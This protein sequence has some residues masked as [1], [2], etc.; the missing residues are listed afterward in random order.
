MPLKYPKY[1]RR[2]VAKGRDY[3]YFDTGKVVDG[4][5]VLVALPH[6]RDPRFGGSYAALMGHRHRPHAGDV[7]RIPKLVDLYE[8]SPRFRRRSEATKRLYS[9][10]LRKLEALLPTAPVSE[11]TRG[12]IRKLVDG[13]ADTPGAAN[14]FLKVCGVLFAW[15]KEG[16]YI[17]RNPCDGLAKFEGGEHDPWPDHIVNAALE[18]EDRTVRLL[19]HLLLYTAQRIGDVVRMTWQDLANGR[20]RVVI[21]KTGRTLN[22]RQHKRLEAELATRPRDSIVVCTVDGQPIT[23]AQ[24]RYRLQKFTEALGCKTVPH[25]LRKNAVNA[26][27]EAGCT[28][29]ETAAVSQQSLA[30]VEHY[31]KA[32]DAAKLGDAAILRW[33]NKR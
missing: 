3:F 24:A 30:M 28:A 21:R 4:K 5:R 22:I 10:Y 9:I 12:D 2:K 31:A 14:A 15:A 1:V 6:I 29:A 16:E 26:L 17:D 27:L 25:G 18:A 11:I 8:R 13:M 19:A 33:E 20:V 7:L 32:R 23:E